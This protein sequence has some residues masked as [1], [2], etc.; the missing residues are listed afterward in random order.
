M[1][2][3][4]VFLSSFLLL[5][6][7][8]TGAK[9]GT[10]GWDAARLLSEARGAMS[11]GNYERAKEYY[12]GLESR[13]PF[14]VYGQQA[15][16]DLAYVYYK[17]E[18]PERAIETCNRFIELYPQ[19][20]QIDYAFYLGGL[21]SFY[22]GRGLAQ[23]FLLLDPS[24]RSPVSSLDS[25]ERLFEL[26]RRFPD[27]KYAPDARQRMI[28]LRNLL[29]EHE[30]EVAHYYLRRH[31]YL[32][33]VNR[34]RYVVENYPRSASV[35]DALALMARAYRVLGLEG[36]SKDVLRVLQLNHPGH[37]AIAEVESIRVQ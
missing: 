21:A 1:Y 36:L 20:P 35:P 12:Q 17:S 11:S 14:G 16:L 31:A 15:L 18:E 9:G 23:R 19:H 32:A 33:A 4:T 3:R 2:L 34:A 37:P 24:Q 7:C 27:S 22:R 30:I 8:G 26:V 13:F 10:E 6:G 25:F 5:A 29:A 28:Y